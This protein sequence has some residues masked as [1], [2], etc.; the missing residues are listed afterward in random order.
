MLNCFVEIFNVDLIKE[1]LCHWKW[2]ERIKNVLTGKNEKWSGTDETSSIFLLAYCFCM[3]SVVIFPIDKLL[4]I[5]YS[6]WKYNCAF[7]FT[8]IL[9]NLNECNPGDP[10]RCIAFFLD[11]VLLHRP[12]TRFFSKCRFLQ[13]NAWG[14]KIALWAAHYLR[15]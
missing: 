5:H 6:S 14:L 3:W 11:L 2:F 4:W 8:F 9:W 15:N 13:S 1:R 12:G 10:S 7:T